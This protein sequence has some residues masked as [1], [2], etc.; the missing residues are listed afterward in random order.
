VERVP[1]PLI[2][3]KDMR[4]VPTAGFAIAANFSLEQMWYDR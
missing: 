4:N 3:N 2:V 1:Y